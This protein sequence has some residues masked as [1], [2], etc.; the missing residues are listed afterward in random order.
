MSNP[1]HI[2]R[3]GDKPTVRFVE[4]EN[5]R[6]V[7]CKNEDEALALAKVRLFCDAF[8]AYQPVDLQELQKSIDALERRAFTDLKAYGYL[9]YLKEDIQSGKIS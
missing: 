5:V 6:D 4:G 9:L 7:E 3:T 2:I 1:F 8:E